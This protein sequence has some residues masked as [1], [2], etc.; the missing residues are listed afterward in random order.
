[1]DAKEVEATVISRQKPIPRKRSRKRVKKHLF[2]KHQARIPFP[3]RLDARSYITKMG[4]VRLFGADKTA[5]R[6]QLFERSGGRCEGLIGEPIIVVPTIEGPIAIRFR[7]N[8]PI[9]WEDF[10]WSHHRHGANKTDTLAGG[11]ASCK[12]CHRAKHAQAEGR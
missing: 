7:C 2:P 6:S 3:G 11:I 1:M 12:A 8:R 9:T 5:L 4:R 10:E